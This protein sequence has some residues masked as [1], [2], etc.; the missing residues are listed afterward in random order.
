MFSTSQVAG[1]TGKNHQA[2]PKVVLKRGR[3]EIGKMN[4][5]SEFDQS[6]LHACM[7]T[8]Q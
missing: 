4:S 3:K 1:I 7:E 2:S 5:G 8:L 6:T